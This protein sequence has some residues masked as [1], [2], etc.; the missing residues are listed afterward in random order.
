MQRDYERET[1]WDLGESDTGPDKGR[2]DLRKKV[3][4][5]VVHLQ[6][7]LNTVVFSRVVFVF[8]ISMYMYLPLTSIFEIVI[9]SI[10]YVL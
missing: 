4:A 10:H 6:I 7:Y 9:G 3:V 5:K 8:I 1:S 2:F